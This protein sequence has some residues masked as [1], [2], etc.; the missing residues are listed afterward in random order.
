MYRNILRCEDMRTNLC[1]NVCMSGMIVSDYNASVHR[2]MRI[3]WC[4]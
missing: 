2:A 4:N 3:H 1:V